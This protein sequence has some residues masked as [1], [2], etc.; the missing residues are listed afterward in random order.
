MLC[1]MCTTRLF[2]QLVW[3]VGHQAYPH[4]T[5]TGRRDRLSTIRQKDGWTASIPMAL[6][7]RV[8]QPLSVGHSSTSISAGLGMA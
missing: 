3:D 7:E 8:R 2:D 5:L 1:T 6:R 4:K